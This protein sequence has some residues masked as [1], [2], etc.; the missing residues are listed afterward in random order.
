MESE[1]QFKPFWTN[2]CKD[3]SK[4][5]WNPYSCLNNDFIANVKNNKLNVHV[6]ENKFEP[7][8]K[9]ELKGLVARK[10]R[11]CM[12]KRKK[13][14]L[15]KYFEAYDS[16]YN[17]A[18]YFCKQIEKDRQIN[19]N[20]ED[21]KKNDPIINKIIIEIDNLRKRFN[22]KKDEEVNKK[23]YAEL[24]H[25][26]YV[27]YDRDEIDMYKKHYYIYS[28]EFL[29][30]F[31]VNMS[32][33]NSLVPSYQENIPKNVRDEA[34]SDLC[35]A[36]KTCFKQL[37]LGLIPK[38]KLGF[39]DRKS[40][41]KTMSLQAED[42]SIVDVKKFNGSTVRRLK[43]FTSYFEKSPDKINKK[44][45]Q[46][47]K[48][49]LVLKKQ[50]PVIIKDIDFKQDEIKHLESEKK[51]QKIVNKTFGIPVSHQKEKWFQKLKKINHGCKMTYDGNNIYLIIPIDIKQKTYEQKD[52]I[53]LDP[54]VKTFQTCYSQSEAVKYHYNENKM[55]HL[56]NKH[57][58][59]K[60][61]KSKNKLK[62]AKTK[63]LRVNQRIKNQVDD[64]HWRT[65]NDLINN[66][67]TILLPKFGTQKMTKKLDNKTN[68]RMLI[69]KHYT[70]RQR[71]LEKVKLTD[72]KVYIVDESYTTRTCSGCGHMYNIGRSRTYECRNNN[73]M[74]VMDRDMNAAKN[75]YIKHVC[76]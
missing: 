8:N 15:K 72:S 62:K 13:N 12:K 36:A 32:N 69:M 74:L 20:Y 55:E 68:R 3:I 47:K 67:K 76:I 60:H 59:Y 11:L 48:E 46:C 49:L 26:I 14:I 5:L 40:R 65:I 75:I 18:L 44:I 66:Y 34:V 29:R 41:V 6:D 7:E 42:L 57:D 58:Y 53:A 43:W 33:E 24:K 4:Q 45:T 50:K 61:L 17:N 25:K 52:I 39:K 9:N 22:N 19:N 30:K 10:I 31:F 51:I 71:L 38:F 23:N 70:F 28:L 35:K 54:G 16:T 56:M 27:K 63:I 21:D 37:K 1:I 2:N 73:C 64:M